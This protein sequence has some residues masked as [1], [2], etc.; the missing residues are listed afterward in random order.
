[1]DLSKHLIIF[2]QR[3]YIYFKK[4]LR[5]RSSYAIHIFKLLK[6]SSKNTNIFPR[7]LGILFETIPSPDLFAQGHQS[8]YQNN[9]GNLFKVNN[10]SLM[11]SLNRFHTYF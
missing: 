8:N 5:L 2:Q 4:N 3:A 1:M 7:V 9:M 6:F 11:L 10:M